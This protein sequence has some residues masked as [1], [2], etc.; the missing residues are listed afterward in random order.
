[1]K[2]RVDFHGVGEIQFVGERSMYFFYL[3]WSYLF[4]IQFLQ[5][6]V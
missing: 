5:G 6:S 4:E 1:M 3:I 2:H